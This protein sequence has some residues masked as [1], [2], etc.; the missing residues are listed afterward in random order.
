MSREMILGCITLAILLIVVIWY[1][2]PKIY[3][4]TLDPVHSFRLDI[5]HS[6]LVSLCDEE[7]DSLLDDLRTVII[8]VQ[9]EI[10]S[11]E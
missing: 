8:K 4:W 6:V 1:N 11:C 7:I 10:N 5:Q 3:V 9:E 2:W